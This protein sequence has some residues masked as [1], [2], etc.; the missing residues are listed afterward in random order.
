M[1]SG[2]CGF[3]SRAVSPV[4]VDLEHFKQRLDEMRVPM[5][6]SELKKVVLVKLSDVEPSQEKLDDAE[7]PC[8]HSGCHEAR[9]TAVLKPL[10]V[11]EDKD[12]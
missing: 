5:P 10:T 3:Q 9:A 2:C 6:R 1:A 11:Y 12:N 7:V 4:F 8:L